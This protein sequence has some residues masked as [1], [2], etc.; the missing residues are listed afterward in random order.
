MEVKKKNCS[1]GLKDSRCQRAG[2]CTHAKFHLK[3]DYTHLF[4]HA[5]IKQHL[6]VVAQISILTSKKEVLYYNYGF[7]AED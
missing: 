6:C 3:F 5:E 2:L 4:L 7:S 1:K